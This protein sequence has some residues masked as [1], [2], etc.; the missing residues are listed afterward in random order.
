M[1]RKRI[2]VLM[3]SI[4]RE[5]QQEFAAALV[6]A[7][8]K[9]D[10]DI[11]IFN[12]QGHMNVA[13]STSE[14]GE[15]MI[16][17]LPDLEAFDGII[18]M[19]ATMGSDMALQKIYEIL[20]PLKGI[21]PHISIDVPQEGAVTIRF[22]D[23]SSMDKLTEHLI[24]THSVRNIVFVSGPTD[25]SVS[26][27][28]M[29]ACRRV[30]ERHGINTENCT[31][32]DGQWTRAGGRKAA[33][34]ILLR[35]GGLPEA[36]ICANDDMAL[37][38]IDC[39][40]EHEIRVP[41][42]V[43]VTGFD[44]LREAVMRG[45]T[46]IRRP[47]D[48]SAMKAVEILGRWIDGT[49]PEQKELV[50]P[51][52]LYL[53]DSCGCSR[54]TEHIQ[55]K[56][57]ALGSERWDMETIL[58]RASM[59]SGTMAGVGDEREARE[60]ISEF[61]DSWK[62]R[63]F[64]LCVNPSICRE[65]GNEEPEKG[66]PSG[67]LMLYGSKD[68]RQY[69]SGMIPV[70]G[71]VPAME[72]ERTEAVCLVFCPLYYRDRS[73]GYVAMSPGSGTGS[74]LY[75]VLMLLNGALMSLYLQTS[76]KRSAAVIERMATEDIMTGL[77]NRRGYMEQAP[78]VLE[79]A[80]AQGRIFALLSADMDHMK[81]INDRYGHLAGDEAICRMGRALR[82]LDKHGITPVHI[83][84]DEFIAYG[85]VENPAEAAQLVNCVNSE[86]EQINRQDPW[87]CEISAS[88]GVFA[89]Y[90]RPEDDL[91]YFMTMADRL[92]YAD[93]NKRKYHRRKDDIRP[94]A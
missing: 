6:S 45:L 12:S 93:K 25:S 14:T 56:L 75:P 78:K 88:F 20:S 85:I 17:D 63:E 4:D 90:P 84:G 59:F 49:E 83:S 11:C 53:G 9:N 65:T 24:D 60:I 19:P 57:R 54:S 28:R 67:M 41:E 8:Q 10:T 30:M 33:E 62:I 94:E 89:A 47:V 86:I 51:T 55:E 72:E 79:Q 43:A 42:D 70:S 44:A 74:A 16:Y 22:D 7:G 73:L 13:I 46:T 80:K 87:I 27:E 18:S 34:K 31:V 71:L 68:G 66:Y 81:D 48:V 3:A 92:M 91:D 64:Y 2:A 36:V 76:I 23:R 26:T 21:K 1:R 39:L 29:E 35:P 77:L 32:Y 82:A 61:V 15:S 5:Y 52:L 69:S 40:V 38:L 37:S 50:L 58:A